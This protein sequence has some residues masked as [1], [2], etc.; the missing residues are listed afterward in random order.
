MR[1]PNTW[2]DEL[3]WTGREITFQIDNSQSTWKI[4]KKIAES[5]KF[6]YTMLYD[7]NR[8]RSE[9]HGV[10]AV[11]N[12]QDPTQAAALKIWMQVVWFFLPGK[13]S[14]PQP[15]MGIYSKSEIDCLERLTKAGCSST[16][17]LL[18]WKH[19][20]QGKK[21]VIPGGYIDYM[22]MDMLPGVKPVFCDTGLS[23][24]R[25]VQ[26][27]FKKAWFEC[28]SHGRDNRSRRSRNLLWDRKEQK[29]YIVDWEHWI[30]TTDDT[31]WKNGMFYRWSL[32][33][34][35]WD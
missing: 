6:D 5:E 22:L 10:F 16:P 11:S 29:C 21:G 31:V 15:D 32:D 19:N 24:K 7:N 17:S 14:E 1:R 27:A 30:E 4:Y 35:Y 12:V 13:T 23:E 25:E 2:F 26:D 8:P 28:V 33:D 9:A 34:S 3:E 20:I 18:A